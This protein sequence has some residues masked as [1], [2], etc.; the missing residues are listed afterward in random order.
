M[1]E[2]ALMA[3]PRDGANE[4]KESSGS[5]DGSV[6]FFNNS[7]AVGYRTD[8]ESGR[9]PFPKC[10]RFY[11]DLTTHLLTHQS[12]RP[13]KCPVV[14]CE[15]HQ[16][17]FARKFDKARHTLTHYKG[18]WE[19][20]FCSGSR[21]ATGSFYSRADVFKRHLIS[22]HGVDRTPSTPPYTVTSS[23]KMVSCFVCS[24]IQH[25]AQ[26]FYE[27][28]DGCI[29]RRV[30]RGVSEA[31]LLNNGINPEH[32]S[33][34]QLASFAAQDPQI[35]QKSLQV[36]HQNLARNQRQGM[37][38]QSIGE[39]TPVAAACATGDLEH[40]IH[41]MKEHPH[42]LNE[43]DSVRRTPL[44]IAVVGGY[45]EIVQYLIEKGCVVD[46]QDF[47]GATPLTDAVEN[48]N[49]EI[50]DLL[51]KAGANPRLPNGMGL[52]PLDLVI[53]DYANHDAIE[54][55]L[56]AALERHSLRFHR[57]DLT[58]H[59]RESSIR[60]TKAKIEYL[61]GKFRNPP[62]AV[63]EALQELLKVLVN[64]ESD[65]SQEKS[66][67]QDT[68]SRAQPVSPD[69]VPPLVNNSSDNAPGTVCAI[70]EEI[71]SRESLEEAAE[72]PHQCVKCD[73]KLVCHSMTDNLSSF[74]TNTAPALHVNVLSNDISDQ[75][76][77]SITSLIEEKEDY[78]I[79]CFCGFRRDDGNT[80]FCDRCETWQHIEC[81]YFEDFRNGL[82]PDV[83]AIEHACVDCSPRQ[84][85]KKSA[86]ERQKDRF[87][88]GK[89]NIKKEDGRTSRFRYT[90]F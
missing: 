64:L 88:L 85:D 60:K 19:C 39:R 28:L 52:E 80:V 8:N 21:S 3:L 1:E 61:N 77:D 14:T 56:L 20:G 55:S 36:Y 73:S 89:R 72:L 44:Q 38:R 34:D 90:F 30:E 17:G 4:A 48:G 22:V 66:L 70:A 10:G 62:T 71:I 32:L 67:V 2:V 31:L 35:Q 82:A 53:K 26:Q 87:L 78:T 65:E 29:I 68:I 43:P 37:P 75:A 49:P 24:E 40:L 25:N 83:D 33:Q 18:I 69:G 7:G 74:H 86:S 11:K 54:R 42:Y 47:A 59:D 6:M 46:T 12:E 23:V 45:V 76:V 81:Y 51:L 79:N 15:Y 41:E 84:H 63:K 58:A 57:E 5:E 27:H 9:C 50:V 13:E 16:K